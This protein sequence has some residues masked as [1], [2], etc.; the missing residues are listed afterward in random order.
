MPADYHHGVRVIELTDGARPIRT[1]ESAVIG[2]VGTAPDADPAVFP[3]NTPVLIAG[4]RSKAAKLDTVGTLRG[5][6]PKAMDAIF[7]Q[8]GAMIVVVRVEEGAG[9]TDAEKLAATVSNVIGGVDGT[10]G[11][12]KGLQAMLT[13]KT[14]LG[15][16]P[17]ILGVP[18]IDTQAVAAEL[19]GIADSLRAFAYVSAYGAETAEA[20]VLYRKNFGSKR[21]MVIWPDFVGW[22]TS[23]NSSDTLH[24]VARA[25]GLRAKLDND[26]GWHKTLSNIPVNGV[27]GISK[28][29]PWDLQDP[30]T[31][32]GYLNAN[33]VTTL[34]RESG[35]RFWGSR[36]CSA[37]PL[38]A[39]ESAT[40]TGDILADT[41]AEA[42]LWAIDKP[43]SKTLIKDILD[44]VNTKFRQLKAQGYIVDGTAWVDPEKNDP[45]SL[46]A[47]KLYIDYDYTP[48]PPL[49]NLMFYQRITTNYL[50]QLVA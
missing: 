2:I 6:L 27:T 9:A 48:V 18:G 43:M 5:T 14:V 29:V 21:C 26:I 38:F 16:K 30:N 8:I 11:Q 50:S 25:L 13:A 31:V 17:R 19:I 40:R 15:I 35:F 41:I 12:H 36:T 23:T 46:A 39:F 20:A 45:L 44:G 28:D 47:G 1:V 24:A 7:D 4:S 37:D 32:A 34:I 10:T 42:H 49:E 33:E 3:L 22:N